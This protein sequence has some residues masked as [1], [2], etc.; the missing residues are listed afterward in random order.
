MMHTYFIRVGC[1]WQRVTTSV[2]RW[3]SLPHVTLVGCRRVAG[4]LPLL[5]MAV[6]AGVVALPIAAAV[7]HARPVLAAATPV[8]TWTQQ[9]S[10]GIATAIGQGGAP[11]NYALG[12]YTE[13][14]MG[15][16]TTPGP[17]YIVQGY[18]P[19]PGAPSAP[20]APTVPV[21]PI[22]EPRSLLLLGGAIVLAAVIRPIWRA[23]AEARRLLNEPGKIW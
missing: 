18:P 15:G 9:P 7:N 6:A 13:A 16:S 5:P 11:P 1:Q 10:V 2:A 17:G 12:G 14:G 20:I 21:I 4:Q 19:P 8:E 22:P 23:A 3:R